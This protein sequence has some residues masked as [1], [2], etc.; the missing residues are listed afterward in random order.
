MFSEKWPTDPA[1]SEIGAIIREADDGA[2]EAGFVWDEFLSAQGQN[3][4]TCMHLSLRIGALAPDESV[5]RNGR[6]FLYE[7][8]ARDCLQRCEAFLKQ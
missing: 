2:H 5:T 6:I 7:G 4:W 3:P 8:D 1:N